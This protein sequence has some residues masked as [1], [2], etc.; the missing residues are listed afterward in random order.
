MLCSM[1]NSETVPPACSRLLCLGGEDGERCEQTMAG[2]KT[3]DGKE[4]E[5]WDEYLGMLINAFKPALL[6]SMRVS[7]LLCLIDIQELKDKA[8]VIHQKENNGDYKGATDELLMAIEISDQRGK[9]QMFLDALKEVEDTLI[10]QK[11]LEEKSQDNRLSDDEN[12]CI[13]RI[14]S[15]DI[16]KRLKLSVGMLNKMWQKQLIMQKDRQMLQS[17]IDN[18]KREDANNILLLIMHRHSIDWYSTFLGILCDDV[19]QAALAELIDEEFCRKRRNLA[20]ESQSD[21]RPPPP[22]PSQQVSAPEK[23]G[24]GVV[25]PE[26]TPVVQASGGATRRQA[27]SSSLRHSVVTVRDREENRLM[28]QLPREGRQPVS[29]SAVLRCCPE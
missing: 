22:Q 26:A 19:H 23:D 16:Q 29:V 2:Y 11:L 3:L 8:G 25:P 12:R 7:H 6:D 10:V 27:R 24:G 9:W 28:S 18:G 4:I 15:Y 20:K 5:N 1:V 21:K 13:L 17:L 14:F